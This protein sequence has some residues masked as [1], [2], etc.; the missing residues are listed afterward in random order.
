MKLLSGK[1]SKDD[2]CCLFLPTYVVLS[3]NMRTVKKFRHKWL[4][5]FSCLKALHLKMQRDK[6]QCF[7]RKIHLRRSL[8]VV[9]SK[10]SYNISLF[11]FSK[12]FNYI[13]VHYKLARKIGKYIKIDMVSDS[14]K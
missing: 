3:N 2:E 11:I 9:V 10:F 4:M 6:S 8:K 13:N 7:L 12:H 14:K 5:V 1:I